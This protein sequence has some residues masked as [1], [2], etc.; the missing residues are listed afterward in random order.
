[1]LY[2]LKWTIGNWLLLECVSWY[3]LAHALGSRK[4][5]FFLATNPTRFGSCRQCDAL[6]TCVTNSMATEDIHPIDLFI[7]TEV[8]WQ[9]CFVS[10]CLYC[11]RSVTANKLLVREAKWN[12]FVWKCNLKVNIGNMTKI[13]KV[14]WLEEYLMI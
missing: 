1:M 11:M 6:N 2:I 8:T 5:R 9:A 13:L 10:V 4:V 3:T 7:I 12:H 14:F